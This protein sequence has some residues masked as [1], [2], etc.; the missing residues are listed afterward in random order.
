MPRGH[1]NDAMTSER[2]DSMKRVIVVGGGITGLAAAH[3]VQEVAQ[4][5]RMSVDVRLLE[6]RDSIGGTIQTTQQDGFLIE[7]GPDSFIT[8]KPAGL[9]LCRST[10]R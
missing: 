4:A 9:A 8:Q 2:T 6:A 3:R 7:G 5:Q 1:I 10:L